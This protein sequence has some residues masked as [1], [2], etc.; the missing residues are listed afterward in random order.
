M[1]IREIADV[2][3]VSPAAVSIVLN[4]RKGVSDETRKRIRKVIDETGYTPNPRT[5]NSSRT[6]LCIK[7]LHGGVLVEENEGFIS[8]IVSAMA[9]RCRKE[10]YTLV[11]IEARGDMAE[12]IRGVDFSPYCGAI[13]IATELPREMYGSLQAIP[14]PFVSVDNMMPGMHYSCV[15]IDNRENV[16]TA[17]AYIHSCGYRRVGYLRSAYH[18]E[19]FTAR[20]E[21]F[22]KY[23]REMG[24]TVRPEDVREIMATMIGAHEDMRKLLEAKPD[25]ELPE[26]FFADN[27]TV[28]LGA[29]KALKEAGC[30]ISEDVAV[31]GFDNIPYSAISTPTLTTIHVQRDLIGRQAVRQLLYILRDAGFVSAKTSFVGNLVERGSMNA[32]QRHP[33]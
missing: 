19:N 1:T 12:W 14:V 24:F 22:E 26:C 21:A 17:L 6:V 20:A 13:V 9:E 23:S 29:I 32:G 10:E 16:H 30:R 5:K 33:A 2:A 8:A 4:G 27:D 31:I 7:Y 25:W 3:G 28:A 11:Q 18:A 15:G